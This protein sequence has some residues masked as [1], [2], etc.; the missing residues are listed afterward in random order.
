MKPRSGNLRRHWEASEDRSSWLAVVAGLV[1]LGCTQANVVEAEVS[2][3]GVPAAPPPR[4]RDLVKLEGTSPFP[5]PDGGVMAEEAPPPRCG[6]GVVNTSAEE[7]DDGIAEDA[8]EE[9]DS[10]APNSDED[11]DGTGGSGE[12]DDDGVDSCSSTCES[13]DTPV[14]PNGPRD[15]GAVAP[16]RSLGGSRHPVAAGPNG[17]AIAHVAEDTAGV[18]LFLS[19]FTRSGNLS[20]LVR[21]DSADDMPPQFAEPAVA[22]LPDGSFAVAWTDLAADEEE[23]GIALRHVG[24]DGTVSTVAGVTDVSAFSQSEP[25]LMWTGKELI[26]AWTDDSDPFTFPDLHYRRFDASLH[27]VEGQQILAA[28]PD[29]EGRATLAA[30]DGGWGAAWRTTDGEREEIRVHYSLGT[31]WQVEVTSPGQALDHPALAFSRGRALV[32]FT[33][34]EDNANAG[35]SQTSAIWLAVL[36]ME[37]PQPSWTG[38]LEQVAFPDHNAALFSQSAPAVVAAGEALLLG[39]QSESEPGAPNG[40]DIWLKELQLL[41]DDSVDLSSAE[42]RGPRRDEDQSGHQQGL[43][44]AVG[45]SAP[46]PVLLSAWTAHGGTATTTPRPDVVAQF[47]QVPLTR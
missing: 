22:A 18:K 25:D 15:T 3:A 17:F 13:V 14:V 21:L 6:D 46:H 31:D 24:A 5:A 42:V 26:L 23:L 44:L 1:V 34:G 30:A 29:I 37:S 45:G 35:I 32:A 10:G 38:A 28:S 36:G 12:D 20:Q 2:D 19:L 40:T 33:E 11:T 47:A 41:Q 9:M 16:K 7:C 4:L 43:A 8:T 39:W 27:P